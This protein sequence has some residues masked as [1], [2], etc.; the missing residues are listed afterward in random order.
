MNT[1]FCQTGN[2]LS[3]RTVAITVINNRAKVLDAGG[4]IDTCKFIMDFEKAFDT[5]TH[6]LLKCKLHGYG[7]SEIS[8]QRTCSRTSR[9]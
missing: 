5:H 9:N 4:Q 7:I 1:S 8:L 6:E 3:G 2:T